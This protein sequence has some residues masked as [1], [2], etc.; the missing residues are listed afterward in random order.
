[1]WGFLVIGGTVL[2]EARGNGNKNIG[3]GVNLLM[4]RKM[5]EGE[6]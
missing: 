6:N 5:K 1:M 3:E 2:E 4:G